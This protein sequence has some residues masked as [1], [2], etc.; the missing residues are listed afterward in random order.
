M[1]SNSVRSVAGRG[2]RPNPM[3]AALRNLQHAVNQSQEAVFICDPDGVIERVNPAF[4]DLT[5]YSSL[6]AVGKDLSWIV[7]D[8]PMSDSYRRLWE[9]VFQCRTYHRNL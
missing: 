7:A 2:P 3:A 8:G 1:L 9:Q 6:D 4:E 5:G